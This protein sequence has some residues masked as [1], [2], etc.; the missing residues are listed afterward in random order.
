MSEQSEI[1][2]DG[3]ISQKNSGRGSIQKGDAILEPFVV[4]Y[5]EYEKS[6]SVSLNVWAKICTD[7]FRSGRRQP[8]LK[9]VLGGER[10]KVRVWVIS[11][12]MFNEMREAWLKQ[13]ALQDEGNND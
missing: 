11:E 1:K 10:E 12:S 6:F 2:R 3:A 9:L 13:N 5:K 7:A 4:D 8:A